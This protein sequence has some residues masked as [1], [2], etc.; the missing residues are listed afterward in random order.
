MPPE[1]SRSKPRLP[2]CRAPPGGAP[3]GC[4]HPEQEEAHEAAGPSLPCP[5]PPRTVTT[6]AIFKKRPMGVERTLVPAEAFPEEAQR[7][8]LMH[9]HITCGTR[10]GHG[11]KR[12]GYKGSFGFQRPV[13]LPVPN[14]AAGLTRVLSSQLCFCTAREALGSWHGRNTPAPSGLLATGPPEPGAPVPEAAP[15]PKALPSITPNLEPQRAPENQQQGSETAAG[16]CAQPA[17]FEQPH[18]CTNRPASKGATSHF[19]S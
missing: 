17:T 15:D 1:P 14:Q 19:S 12:P 7:A 11:S 9:L 13:T 4:G 5:A 8:P 6:D 16:S 2:R 18:Q 3:H 10:P